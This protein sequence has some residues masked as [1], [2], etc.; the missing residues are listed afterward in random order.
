MSC[1]NEVVERKT[2]CQHHLLKITSRNKTKSHLP[3]RGIHPDDYDLDPGETA[4]ALATKPP[5]DTHGLQKL[6]QML[7]DEPHNVIG[8]DCEFRSSGGGRV[9]LIQIAMYR[10]DDLMNPIIDTTI[11]YGCPI[12]QLDTLLEEGTALSTGARRLVLGRVASLY[13]AASPSTEGTTS[14]MTLEAVARKIQSLNLPPHAQLLDWSTSKIDWKIYAALM[15][16][17]NMD[18]GQLPQQWGPIHPFKEWKRA[19][20]GLPS[21]KLTIVFR[22]VFPESTLYLDAH[23]ASADAKML[24][25]LMRKLVDLAA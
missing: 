15:V 19:L 16:L 1:T 23:E 13:H 10:F 6:R 12:S 2:Y 4:S 22:S 25:M 14:G 8:I 9:V 24:I 17:L 5:E 18:L 7:S 20:P 11:D 3:H 21:Y